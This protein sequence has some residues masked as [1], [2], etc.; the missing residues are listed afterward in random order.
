[1]SALRLKQTE[2]T[3]K[4]SHSDSVRK[5]LLH[6]NLF[7][8]RYLHELSPDAADRIIRR[9]KS[10]KRIKSASK[11]LVWMILFAGSMISWIKFDLSQKLSVISSQP[12]RDTLTNPKDFFQIKSTEEKELEERMNALLIK[13]I[14]LEEDFYYKSPE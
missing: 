5:Y 10:R 8:I 11:L 13:P 1:M 4:Y 14:G 3:P 7:P 12:L 9:H 2:T 6:H